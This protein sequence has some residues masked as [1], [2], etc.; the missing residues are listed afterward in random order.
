LSLIPS[1]GLLILGLNLM[2]TANAARPDKNSE[3][4]SGPMIG[5]A[6]NALEC[7]VADKNL[8]GKASGVVQLAWRGQAEQAR[9]VLDMAGT[10][11]IHSV[12]VNGQPVGTVPIHP[13]GQLCSEG[14]PFYLDIPA[15]TLVQGVN[16]IEITDDAMTGDNWSA[17]NIRLE[18]FGKI[19]ALPPAGLG[20]RFGVADVTAAVSTTFIFTF[21]NPYDGSSQPAIAQIPDGY[22]SGTPTPLVVYA[23][24]RNGIMEDG[25]NTLGSV[26]NAKGWLLASPQMH[27]DWPIPQVCYVNPNDPGCDYDDKVLL[28]KP[29][30]F[31]YASL[32]SQYD[33]IGTVKY[34]LDHY[35][36]KPDQI[37][38]VG[39]SM[40]GQIATVTAA[41]YPHI[42]AAVFDN[43]GP[44]NMSQW[45]DESDSYY[46]STMEKEC[47]VDG[48]PQ[49]PTQ[50]SFCY[51]RR[52]SINFASDYTHTPISITHSI[53]DTLVP[54]HH[55]RD[56]RDA[57][58]SYG[59]D[60]LAFVY[61]D[62]IIGPTCP[63]D[64]HCYNPNPMTA[65]N[66]LGQFTLNNNPT[67]IN[68][69][70]DESKSY[71]WLN[72]LQTG[73][74]HWSHL[75]VAYYPISATVAAIVSDTHPLTMG[76]NLGSVST[77]G[78]IPQPGMGLPATTY[79]VKGGGLY[80][81]TDYVSGYLTT[82]LATTGQYTLTIS[83][84]TASL[85]A[86]PTVISNWQAPTSTVTAI[87]I[88]RL[89]N[90]APDGTVVQFSATKGIFPNASS[91]Y[92]ATTKE[93][94]VTTTLTLTP[95][96]GL[97]KVTAQVESITTT[98]MVEIMP[99]KIYL[100]TVV[101]F[102]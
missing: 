6:S 8:P 57:I 32:Q 102:N 27:G 55:S 66:F 53:S 71:Y 22:S 44:T 62:T 51:Q 94:Q 67:R 76:L 91:M 54:I 38:L 82:S 72:L 3:Q 19:A 25:I 45:Y 52:S 36:I 29:G 42:F 43:K 80:S 41:K 93:G 18:V 92:T 12:K 11:A 59:P 74:D 24:G 15:R 58:N 7:L 96:A 40:G 97:A 16:L 85:S 81:L 69:T 14:E 30:A 99:I 86:S 64:Y 50:N 68:I 5:L 37:Y 90:P 79:L 63:P 26:A 23:H 10:E 60:Q 1:L 98:T 28:S 39:Y 2:S 21:T 101:K 83:A 61:E 87:I 70:S 48:N 34:M 56:L 47:H 17:A 89:N 73:S 49:T 65:L 84:I 77:I 20:D 95:S 78:I 4:S 100:P 13:G 35:N 75:Q 31:A 88:D 9:L 33:V 46:K